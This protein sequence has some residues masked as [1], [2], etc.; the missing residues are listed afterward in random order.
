MR[1]T[2]SENHVRWQ[3]VPRWVL[4]AV[5][6]SA[7]VVASWQGLVA[8]GRDWL[9]LGVGSAGAVDV[10]CGGLVHG[11]VGVAVDAAG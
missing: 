2:G 6:V 10:G 1:V 8:V 7:P 4:L 9:G 3:V 5:V 11:G